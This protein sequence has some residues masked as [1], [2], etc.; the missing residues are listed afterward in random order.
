MLTSWRVREPN[1]ADARGDTNYYYADAMV[2]HLKNR[3]LFCLVFFLK[4]FLNTA[5]YLT[6][7]SDIHE[8]TITFSFTFLSITFK[9]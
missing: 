6:F 5:F 3:I 1:Y 4:T 9:T 7:H 2:A 8:G